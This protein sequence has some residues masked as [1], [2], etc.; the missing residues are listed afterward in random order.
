MNIEKGIIWSNI[1]EIFGSDGSKQPDSRVA[2]Y[3][4]R[5]LAVYFREIN[6]IL[7]MIEKPTIPKESVY[8]LPGDGWFNLFKKVE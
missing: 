4:D 3:S 2:N 6:G 7:K 8:D 1:K 5:I